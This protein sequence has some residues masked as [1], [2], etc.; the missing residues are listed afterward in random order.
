MQDRIEYW[1]WVM[2]EHAMSGVCTCVE[3]R[4]HSSEEEKQD[5]YLGKERGIMITYWR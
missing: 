4:E 3:T 1:R 5:V 2:R